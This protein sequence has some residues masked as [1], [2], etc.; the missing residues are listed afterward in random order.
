MIQGTTDMLVSP[1]MTTAYY[2]RVAARY[3]G[4]LKSFVRYYV[5]PGFGHAGGTFAL[6]WDSLAAIDN[7][8]ESGQAPVTPVVKD[9]NAANGSRTR[10][11]CEY[12][13]FPKYSGSGDVNSA[14]SFTCAEG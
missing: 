12:P 4:S 1:Y 5:Q 9:G 14:S 3:G 6:Q 11:M 13:L 10:P 7:W 8:V 2:N